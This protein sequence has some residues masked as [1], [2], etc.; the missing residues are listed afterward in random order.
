[1]SPGEASLGEL[2]AL[3]GEACAF[4]LKPE[5]QPGRWGSLA[6]TAVDGGAVTL[7]YLLAAPGAESVGRSPRKLTLIDGEGGLRVSW[8]PVDEDSARW[9][10]IARYLHRP[11][12]G[13]RAI[14]TETSA[15]TWLHGD[16]GGTAVVDYWVARIDAGENFGQRLRGVFGA[17]G[18]GEE[19]ALNRETE[20][21]LL[22]GQVDGA[23]SDCRV[24]YLSNTSLHL[25]PMEGARVLS[26]TKGSTASGWEVP[27]PD[28]ST[29]REQRTNLMVGGALAFH[30]A[31]GIFVRVELVRVS[32]GEALIRRQIDLEGGRVFPPPPDPPG[33]ARRAGGEF[34]LSFEDLPWGAGA[35]HYTR[36]VRLALE[37]QTM[38]G[39]WEEVARTAP[40][41]R[42]LVFSPPIEEADEA[43]SGQVAGLAGEDG[44]AAG[45]GGGLHLIRCRARQILAGGLGSAA[46]ASFALLP[47]DDGSPRA[48]A[49]IIERAL[50]DLAQGEFSARRRAQAALE[51]LGP[52][53]RE[54]LE[55]AL[56][57]GNPDLAAAAQEVLVR[58][59]AGGAPAMAGAM[60]KGL[61]QAGGQG[62]KGGQGAQGG[63]GSKGGKGKVPGPGQAEQAGASAFGSSGAARAI[64]LARASALDL[65]PPPAEWTAD[66]PARRALALLRAKGAAAQWNSA[67]DPAAESWTALLGE[68]D[69]EVS[70]RQL[71]ALCAAAPA[72]HPRERI[73]WRRWAARS[74]AGDYLETWGEFFRERAG[75]VDRELVLE[76]L[77]REIPGAELLVA[78]AFLAV[79]HELWSAPETWEDELAAWGR[80]ELALRLVE[81]YRASGGPALLAAAREL[82]ANQG[83]GIRAW[84]G[85]ARQWS[86]RAG[87]GPRSER[88][89]GAMAGSGELHNAAAPEE[90]S[91]ETLRIEGGRDGGARLAAALR[92]LRA[93]GR[94]DVDLILGPGIY[95][96]EKPGSALVLEVPGLRLIGEGEPGSG[97]VE[98]RGGIMVGKCRGVVLE[99]LDILTDGTNALSLVMSEVAVSGCRLRGRGSCIMVNTSDLLL[100]GCELLPPSSGRPGG[101]LLSSGGGLVLARDSLLAAGPVSML[102]EA[103]GFLERCVLEA[104]QRNAIEGG[105]TGRITLVDCLVAS[106]QV[107]LSNMAGALLEGV[108]LRCER[109]P[110]QNATGPVFLCPEH[111]LG[112]DKGIPAGSEQLPSCPL[113]R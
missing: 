62:V 107:G 48:T 94:E 100:E 74:S 85:L 47:A 106:E 23:R 61:G 71:A 108:L 27:S 64:L 65:A 33:V 109:G 42:V 18:P 110:L 97:A 45:D 90:E 96:P 24:A 12:G 17:L 43:A 75:L 25:E 70:V 95:E 72:A 88:E 57:S 91:R 80:A 101:S 28:Q 41:E 60:G 55:G 8:P 35:G 105:R 44:A 19:I 56:A 9:R 5:G 11:G 15:S 63:N 77:A 82:C 54:A 10:V 68:S 34:E 46:G 98:L 38:A 81:R 1:M 87:L 76:R 92:E 6:V 86:E 21:N 51:L 22:T 7:E 113:V 29:Y 102:G 4:R 84:R 3:V 52:R 53:A 40:G 58:T 112:L 83:A 104:G 69:P 36:G 14:Q 78:E 30:L 66:D 26:L 49:A 59:G 39:A 103:R 73:P 89:L 50:G 2:P 20:V 32:A 99:N 13:F 67:L 79:A 111:V 31:E 37:T 16:A 93:G